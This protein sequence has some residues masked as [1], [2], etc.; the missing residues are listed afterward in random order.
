[1]FQYA[2]GRALARRLRAKLSLDLTGFENYP[3]RSYKLHHFDLP[4]SIALPRHIRRATRPSKLVSLADELLGRRRIYYREKAFTFDSDVLCLPDHTY[5]DGYWQSEKYFI[6]LSA[7]IRREF[8]PPGLGVA[9]DAIWF[10]R[11]HNCLS[12]SLHVRRGDYVSEDKVAAVHGTCPPDYYVRASRAIVA[13]LGRKPHFFI[14][15]DDPS[16]AVDNLHLEWLH[17]L[18]SLHDQTADRDIR[19]FRL[20]TAC[21]HHIV[22]NSSFSWWAAWLGSEP[23]KI[24]IAPE[25]WFLS[26]RLDDRDLI[27]TGWRRI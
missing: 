9:E 25:R 11:I 10:D 5:L 6:D 27:P 2:A 15:S 26:P 23:G 4:A 18:V 16:W 19:E 13:G 17:S 12:V 22:A 24:V 20:M 7:T 1:M 21:K 14:F 8:T 3:K